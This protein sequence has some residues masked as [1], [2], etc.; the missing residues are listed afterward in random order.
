MLPAQALIHHT[1]GT[2]PCPGYW[3]RAAAAAPRRCT[4]RRTWATWHWW[5]CCCGMGP[6]PRRRCVR[7]RHAVTAGAAAKLAQMHSGVCSIYYARQAAH[8][9]QCPGFPHPVRPPHPSNTP[10]A[11]LRALRCPHIL[12]PG[13][14]PARP[15]AAA[16]LLEAV[17]HVARRRRQYGAAPGGARRGA[18][19]GAGRAAAPCERA[20][21]P[22]GRG[23]RAGLEGKGAGVT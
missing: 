9:L 3:R 23:A 4:T 5:S 14:A 12:P 17:R 8:L 18:A 1:S 15:G 11:A 7:V 21:G 2:P 22:R 6:T 20:W 13:A 19:R 10:P 16:R